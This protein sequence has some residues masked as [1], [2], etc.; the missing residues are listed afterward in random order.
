MKCRLL[1]ML[2]MASVGS[3]SA[4]EQPD[5]EN[6]QVLGRNKEPAHATL[7]PYATAEQALG[8]VP[9]ASPYVHSL[10]GAWRFRWAPNPAER[11]RG[12]QDPD[13]D[14][15]AWGEIDVPSN[16]QTRGY[17]VPIYTNVR[18]PFVKRWPK[19]T[20]E[21]PADWTAFAY[22]NPVGS[23]RRAFTVPDD[24]TGGEVFIHFA[25]VKSASIK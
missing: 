7:A 23:Y 15:S 11:P 24:W 4:A 19:V 13:Y 6:Q 17:G 1:M 22:R 16:W 8:G 5:W 10:N 21:P 25:G 20:E 12:F 3:R 18:Y 14:V 2:A 9:S